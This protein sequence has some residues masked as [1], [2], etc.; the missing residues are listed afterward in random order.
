MFWSPGADLFVC[1]TVNQVKS[2]SLSYQ[3]MVRAVMAA[4]S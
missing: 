4:R 2:R 3:L 1:G